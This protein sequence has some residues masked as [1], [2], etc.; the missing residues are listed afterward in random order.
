MFLVPVLSQEGGQGELGR[1]LHCKG[2]RR[3]LP[4]V[5]TK[6]LHVNVRFVYGGRLHGA[7]Y[8]TQN[9]TAYAKGRW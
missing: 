6:G 4:S 7:V 1:A 3:A 8:K 9:V 5:G 2:N